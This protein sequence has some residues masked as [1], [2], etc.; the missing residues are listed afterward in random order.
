MRD[1][2]APHF[3]PILDGT[4]LVR[5]YP[6]FSE[7]LADAVA[8]GLSA[9]GN[10]GIGSNVVTFVKED[11]QTISGPGAATYDVIGGGTNDLEVTITPSSD[12]SRVLVL[13]TVALAQSV[14]ANVEEFL[15]LSIFRGSTN[16]STPDTLGTRIAALSGINQIDSIGGNRGVGSRSFMFLDSPATTA[17]TTY[18]VRAQRRTSGTTFFNRPVTDADDFF[19]SRAVS[20]IT[21]IEVAS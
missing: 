19:R 15:A 16:L 10:A 3:I 1:T 2:G 13:A 8:D 4:E 18:S 5:A 14:G 6:D 21:A 11:T 7:D 12:T 20:V 17:A 9:A